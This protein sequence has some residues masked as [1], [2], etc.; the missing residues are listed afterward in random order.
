MTVEPD[1]EMPNPSDLLVTIAVNPLAWSSALTAL[2]VVIVA[3][4]KLV[5]VIVGLVVAAPVVGGL[6]WAQ[7]RVDHPVDSVTESYSTQETAFHCVVAAMLSLLIC[8][9]GQGYNRQF[10]KGISF[11]VASLVG[12]VVFLGWV[13]HLWAAVDA[14]VV[15]WKRTTRA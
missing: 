7:I 10:I 9:A 14:A 8:G 2:G 6:C 4:A 5:G 11:F 1:R 12:W 13:F 3:P 15:A